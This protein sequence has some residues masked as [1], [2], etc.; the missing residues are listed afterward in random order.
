MPVT[1][2]VVDDE[3]D[4]EALL[5]QAFRKA[6]RDGTYA[7]LFARDGVEAL[8]RLAAH[9]EV[10]LVLT[11][12]NMPRLDGL[13]L[14]DR[15]NA[16]ERPLR[17]V[18]VSAYGD[19]ANIRTAMNR[20]AYDFV[21]KPLALDDLAATIR[22]T[23]A[24]VERSRAAVQSQRAL[25]AARQLDALKARF[26]ADLSH[27]FRTPL[28]LIL[29]PLQDALHDGTALDRADL[30]A[31]HRH[32]RRLARL[33]DQLLDLAKIEAGRMTLR[34]ARHDADAFLD[35]L[36][37][38]FAPAAERRRITLRYDGPEAPVPLYFEP[39]KL[40]KIVGNLL[41]NALKYT[42]E[43]GAVRVRLEADD[44]AATISVR[45][46]GPGLPAAVLPHLFDRFYRAGE[47]AETGTGIGLALTKDL[48]ALHGG[49]IEVESDEGFGATFTVRLPRGRDHLRPEDLADAATEPAAPDAGRYLEVVDPG[50]GDARDPA[51]HEDE[52]PA[53]L[54][55]DDNADVRAYL[56][57]RLGTRYRVAEAADGAEA[58]DAIR[59][60]PP[61]L[62]V[63]DVRMPGL[64]G[65]ALCRLLK[66]DP[67]LNHIPIILL[68]ARAGEADP[69]A[70]LGA[71]ADDYLTKPFNASELLLRAENLVGVRRLLRERFSGEVVLRPAD[72]AVPS[73]DAAFVQR[74]QA[75]VEDHMGDRTFD[76]AAVADAVGVSPRQLR[77]R[78]REI[79]G[80]SPSGL[81]RTLRMERAAQLLE[82]RTGTISEI[83]YAVGYED[84]RHFSQLFRQVYGVL[85]SDYAGRSGQ[86]G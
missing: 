66:Q 46:N 61:A 18:I 13:A 64:D 50:E 29:G 28:T 71:G 40:E 33:I 3:P 19:L 34:A 56:R 86:S 21:T 42:P 37:L 8:E 78:I 6:I 80:L 35:D 32:A 52:A 69:L 73:A 55:V 38:S 31:M 47:H 67:A 76:L 43:G 7:F 82:R 79:T 27:E 24:E 60:Q 49:T 85:P 81:V 2:L 74:V 4:V 83:A 36:V 17:V 59:R 63:S 16:L 11:D 41:S 70:G 15:I 25:D 51:V 72:V 62:V 10:D 53:V 39:D 65:Y 5:R 26:F 20:G 77:R 9:P 58:L 23:W 45:D 68:T 84:A 14:L 44:D 12:S 54:V 57:R 30:E 22:K 1:I 75:Y 48:A